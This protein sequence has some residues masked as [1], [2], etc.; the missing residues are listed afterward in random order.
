MRV[1]QCCP[2]SISSIERISI[3]SVVAFV[4]SFVIRNITRRVE[5]EHEFGK[6]IDEVRGCDCEYEYITD[7][8]E[9]SCAYVIDGKKWY[10]IKFRNRW[11][12]CMEESEESD[13]RIG[14]RHFYAENEYH[15]QKGAIDSFKYV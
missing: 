15:T 2:H 8:D 12:A 13:F 1:A 3:M 9:V 6:C 4:F 10:I 5:H 14:N 7:Q 11:Y